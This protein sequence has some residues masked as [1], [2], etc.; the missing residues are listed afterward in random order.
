M[1]FDNTDTYQQPLNTAAV[2]G[3]TISSQK[4]NIL[5]KD[6]KD[7]LTTRASKAV[8]AALTVT[9]TTLSNAFNTH[10]SGAF[11][12]LKTAFETHVSASATNVHKASQVSFTPQAGVSA[13]TVQ[14]AIVQAASMGGGGGSGGG[15]AGYQL[16]SE[17]GQNN[18]YAPLGASGKI[19]A[20]H[21][22]T[23]AGGVN[24]GNVISEPL[25]GVAQTW[26]KPVNLKFIE[27][28]IWGAGGDGMQTGTNKQ[29]GGAG[30]FARK[31]IDAVSLPSSLSYYADYTAKKSVFGNTATPSLSVEA[32]FGGNGAITTVGAF[33]L[34]ADNG[35]GQTL[36]IGKD[37]ES[38][39]GGNGSLNRGGKPYLDIGLP[40]FI[41]NGVI[42]EG[43]GFAC[44][45]VGV[46]GG[47][48]G[49]I[50]IKEYF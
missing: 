38:I 14:A 40:P 2:T 18:G 36:N 7:A 21:L 35:G 4:H 6:H 37:N 47:G 8:V 11:T 22:P 9:V 27:V 3:Q 41:E 28:M 16:T 17:K 30:G 31:K 10:V 26:N 32:P 5:N 12:N 43:N 42:F 34:F 46:T 29:G 33:S 48:L 15:G 23:L 25:S 13:T 1:P 19:P 39:Q 49:Y 24:L 44:G 50:V 20:A 45:G